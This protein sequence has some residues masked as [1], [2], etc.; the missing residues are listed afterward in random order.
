M[1]SLASRKSWRSSAFSAAWSDGV[2][3]GALWLPIAAMCARG[4]LQRN[5]GGYAGG[6]WGSVS[7]GWGIASGQAVNGFPSVA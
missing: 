4:K 3:C 7:G 5:A 6:L 2:L 1:D